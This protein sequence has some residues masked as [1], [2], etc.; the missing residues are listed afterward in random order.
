VP[1]L[2]THCKTAREQAVRGEIIISVLE[3]AAVGM[4]MA[5]AIAAVAS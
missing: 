1:P 2:Q 3:L 4:A 5:L